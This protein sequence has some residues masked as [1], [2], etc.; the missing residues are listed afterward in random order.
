MSLSAEK[1]AEIDAELATFGKSDEVL[2]AVV[3]RAR[4]IAADLSGDDALAELLEGREEAVKAAY[5]A[6]KA[7]LPVR[8]A[9]PRSPVPAPKAGFDEEEAGSGTVELPEAELRQAG[10]P[11][12]LELG[13]AQAFP[14][15]EVTT[16][17]S[18]PP[19]LSASSAPPAAEDLDEAFTTAS[20]DIHG[21]SVEELFADAEPTRAESDP[22]ELA[23]LFDEEEVRLSDPDL[24]LES[25]EDD[26]AATDVPP[27]PRTVPPPL[28]AA[29]MKPAFDDGED[30]MA[31]RVDDLLSSDDDFELLVDDEVLE[32]DSSETEVPPALTASDTKDDEEPKK[33]GG[34]ISR[35]LGRK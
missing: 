7:N 5:E 35:I 6:A 19:P 22:S 29:A 13:D 15:D 27:R 32:L 11:P 3:A 28:P 23:D 30:T 1:L 14:E 17:S 4:E 9:P 16:L 18:V 34:L 21:M 31:S 12:V 10:L 25:L 2:A 33:S 20:S 26:N 24:A 8:P